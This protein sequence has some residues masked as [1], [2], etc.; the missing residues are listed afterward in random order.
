MKKIK[1]KAMLRFT[2]DIVKSFWKYQFYAFSLI[3]FWDGLSTFEFRC[4]KYKA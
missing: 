1:Y 4:V 2:L 3:G